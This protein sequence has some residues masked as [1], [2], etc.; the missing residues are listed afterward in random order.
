M[1]FSKI[2]MFQN[3]EPTPLP[4]GTQ[5]IYYGYI[6]DLTSVTGITDEI[7]QKAI[8]DGT[9]KE[10][11]ARKLDK[12]SAGIA[13]EGSCVVVIVPDGYSAAKDDGFNGQQEFNIN[14]GI[15]NSG[16]NGAALSLNGKA[17]KVYGE[18]KINTAEV[19]IYVN[20]F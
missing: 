18:F 1:P 10:I 9:M 15:A 17:Y 14:N 16:A 5:K 20:I 12:T 13:E 6:R 3:A 4:D 8:T 7:L 2:F 11:D 19:F